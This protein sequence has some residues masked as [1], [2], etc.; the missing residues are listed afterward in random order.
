MARTYSRKK[1][2]SGST[3]P[4]DMK[5]PSWTAH[6]KSVVEQ[7]IVKL[8]KEGNSAGSIGLILRDSY[9]IPDVKTMCGKTITAI[10]KD[11]GV[12]RDIPDDLLAL[13]KR[14]IAIAKHRETNKKDMTAKRGQQ[15]TV[16]KI[17][18]LIRYYKSRGVLDENWTYDKDKAVQWII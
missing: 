8:V 16:S 17:N 12:A 15:L 2:K 11:K 14:D 4:I 9:G 6:D 7:L 5:K 3:K 1:G 18:R 10:M 13:I